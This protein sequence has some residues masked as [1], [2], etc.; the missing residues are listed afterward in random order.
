MVSGTCTGTT[1]PAATLC[2]DGN[3]CTTDSCSPQTGCTY[4]NNTA[5]CDDGNGCTT[6]DTCGGGTCKSGT[7]TCGCNADAD[8]AGQE[9]GNACNGT[10]F[11]D[12]SALPYQC[13]VNASTVV[14]CDAGGNTSCQTNVCNTSTGKCGFVAIA[15][16]QPCNADSSVCT[17]GDA[18][19]SGLCKPG[20]SVS[21]NDN[22]PCTNDS[23]NP[24]S[25]CVYTAN[26][27]PC[28]DGNACTV[29]DSCASSAC[30]P[31]PVAVCSDGNPCTN[32]SCN[33]A[34]GS[35]VYAPNT[36]NCDD[37][38]AC[39]SADK[40]ASGVCAGTTVSC[41]DN[42][43]CTSDSCNPSTGCVYTNNTLPCTDGN[44]CTSGD[45]CGAGTCKGTAIDV[46]T[47]CND[48]NPCT[49][50]G[51][52]P[53]SGCAYANNT[54]SCD[55][56]NGCTTGDVCGG[57]TC[58]SGTNTCG[59]NADADCAGQEDG[60]LCNGTLFCD[61]S[62]L[63]YACKVKAV[64]VVTC[65]TA[66]DN[67][68]AKN[69]CNP[70]TGVCDYVGQND[71]AACNADNS[72][73][74]VGDKC[75]SGTCLPGPLVA[76]DDG[77][78]C[79]TD[80]CDPTTGCKYTPNTLPCSDGNACTLGDV[81]QN[82][83]CL[84][85]SPKV[86]TDSNPCTTDTCSSSTGNCTFTNN[87][88]VCDDGNA[89]TSADVCNAGACKGTSLL[90][91]DNN[92]CTTDGCQ[93][94]TGTCGNVP[95]TG[96]CEDGNACTLGD[97]CTGAACV[98]S[99][100]DCDDGNACTLDDCDGATGDCYHINVMLACNDGDP[101]TMNDKCSGGSCQGQV[102]PCDDGVACTWND[103]QTADGCKGTPPNCDDG[104]PCTDDVC[105]ELYGGG[106]NSTAK[107]C[108][109]TN[110]CTTDSCDPVTGECLHEELDGTPC[111]DPYWCTLNDTCQTGSC[112][113]TPKVCADNDPCTDDL[114]NEPGGGGCYFPANSAACD[115][116]KLCTQSDTCKDGKCN[117]AAVVCSDGNPCTTD[118]CD[119]VKG[120]V[121]TVPPASYPLCDD[122]EPCTIDTFC[123]QGD[124]TGGSLLPCN[125]GL[126]CT[127][128]TCVPGSGC[129][130]T[131]T[132]ALCDD[133]NACTVD[134]CTPI[135]GC[136]SL[137]L[138][139]T[140]CPDNSNCTAGEVCAAGICV[141]SQV[142]CADADP[143]TLDWCGYL[144]GGDPGGA[145]QHTAQTD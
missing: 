136:S 26:T 132:P 53:A 51:C 21:C 56:G 36:L 88:A 74:S 47:I 13:K 91:N 32:D 103:R 101:W 3:P 92:P 138:D 11:C 28:T 120:C 128:D 126:P 76:C 99:Q 37:G 29:G 131:L 77:N 73:C 67:V 34:T 58:K 139:A 145:C 117:G 105:N 8:C 84:T 90:C 43:P 15:E 5:A 78:P 115:D 17:Q 70:T 102:I 79:T 81:C 135:G 60:N 123:Y 100:R 38:N 137:A 122:G 110:D 109:D 24:A 75:T 111:Y 33:A 23:C 66:G 22:N 114:C 116:G 52:N 44:A 49:T 125:D 86:C 14:S 61:K 46:A 30:K 72:V 31:G 142:D 18:C 129:V 89:C 82:G 6:G 45:T 16:G 87:A 1:V 57:G 25:G 54:A 40:C 127:A 65:D 143:C 95:R 62:A 124:C 133:G 2:N 71:N 63:P 41:N 112:V 97:T 134:S 144:P 108:F 20:T 93:P 55:D 121:S 83:G 104:N 59:C 118:A 42:N 9:D 113:G 7:N 68:C 50:D 39:S 96:P 130:H 64:T 35:C 10:L 140:P 119:P 80:S 12:K 98:G 94:A 48:G 85:G 27:A 4:S 141:L 19:Q 69:T 107:F 106:C